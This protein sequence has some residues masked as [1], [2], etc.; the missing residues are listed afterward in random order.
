MD[1]SHRV[2]VLIGIRAGNAGHRHHDIGGKTLQGPARHR[3]SH[4]AADGCVLFDELW[5]HADGGGLGGLGVDHEAAV[6]HIAGTP[7][8]LQAGMPAPRPYRIPPWPPNGPGTWRSGRA[9]PLAPSM[10]EIE[11]TCP[12]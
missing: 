1:Q 5:R 10:L 8:H 7:Q 11:L 12:G 9:A 3:Q 6:E 2:T 4:F